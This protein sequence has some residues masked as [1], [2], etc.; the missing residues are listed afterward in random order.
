MISLL[1]VYYYCFVS[2]VSFVMFIVIIIPI[3]YYPILFLKF[4][5]LILTL[6]SDPVCWLVAVQYAISVH[7]AGRREARQ[8]HSHA[9]QRAVQAMVVDQDA[10]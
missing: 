9:V 10:R 1:S 4:L 5:A 3:H 6:C 8:G 7:P 2:F